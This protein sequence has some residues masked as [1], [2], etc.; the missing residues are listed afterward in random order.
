[1]R[2]WSLV[3]SNTTFAFKCCSISWSFG[4]NFIPAGNP[5]NSFFP[6]Y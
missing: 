2:G 3:T 4:S 5:S 1:M 6:P